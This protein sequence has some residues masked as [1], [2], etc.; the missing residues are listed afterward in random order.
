MYLDRGEEHGI[1]G[2][3]DGAL[4]LT[5]LFEHPTVSTVS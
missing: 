2:I 4:L 5:I 1:E 3:E